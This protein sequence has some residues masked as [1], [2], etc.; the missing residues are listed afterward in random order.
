M[1][2]NLNNKNDNNNTHNVF[3]ERYGKTAFD[4]LNNDD[5]LKKKFNEIYNSKND[6]DDNEKCKKEWIENNLFKR[7]VFIVMLEYYIKQNKDINSFIKNEISKILNKK[8]LENIV[9]KSFKQIKFQYDDYI[10]KIYSI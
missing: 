9:V 2:N 8:Y 6:D 10:N 1:K 7:E 3:F 4:L 5:E